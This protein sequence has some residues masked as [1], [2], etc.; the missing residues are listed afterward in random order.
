MSALATGLLQGVNRLLSLLPLPLLHAAGYTLG[1]L[2]AVLPN[3]H[4]RATLRNLELCYPQMAELERARLLVTSLRET[5]KTMLE[6][7]LAWQGS[8]RRLLRLVKAVHGEGLLQ[9]GIEAGKGVIIA[10]PHL[11]SWEVIGQYLQARHP[12]TCMYKPP[13]SPV[14]QSLMQRGRTHLGMQ[15]APTDAGGVRTLL[16]ALKRGELIGILPDQDPMEGAGVFVP[17]FGIQA[18]TMTLLPKLAARSGASVLVAYAERLS[19]GRGYAVHFHP[20]DEAIR[21]SDPAIAASAMNAA[22]EAAVRECPQQYQWSY[23]R[24]RHRPNREPNIYR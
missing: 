8:R 23:K 4:R 16:G 15:L 7:P 2:V 3:R 14:V 9:Q 18:R 1:S 10:S 20:C 5:A 13:E 12:L 17:F 24:F 6:T 19:W 21:D 22:V 11:G